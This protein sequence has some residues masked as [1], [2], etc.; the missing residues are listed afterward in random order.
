MTTKTL[1]EYKKLKLDSIYISICIC[2]YL[3]KFTKPNYNNNNNNYNYYFHSF[4][5][6]K[7]GSKESVLIIC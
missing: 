6:A 5:F 4:C 1:V 3:S 7:L 2:G